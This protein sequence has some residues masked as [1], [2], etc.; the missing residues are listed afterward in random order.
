MAKGVSVCARVLARRGVA[1]TDVSARQTQPQMYPR[2]AEAK[3]FLATLWSAGRHGPDRDHMWVRVGK[4]HEF[5][6]L[7]ASSESA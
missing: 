7:P 6:S 4:S 2:G 1:A 3:T 5:A